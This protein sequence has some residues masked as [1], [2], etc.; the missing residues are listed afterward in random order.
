MMRRKDTPLCWSRKVGTFFLMVLA[1]VVALLGLPKPAAAQQIRNHPFPRTAQLQWGGAPDEWYAKFD[2]LFMRQ[3]NKSYID[4]IRALNPNLIWLVMR[5]FNRADEYLNGFPDSWF[6]RDSRGNKIVLYGGNT[7]WAN[8]SELAPRA[9]GSINGISFSNQ[10]LL[11]FFPEELARLVQRAGSEGIVSDG[12]Y[13]RLHLEWNMFPDVDLDNNGQNDLTE[14]GKGKNWVIERWV[15]GVDKFLNK[16]RSLLGPNK[17][18][19]INTGSQDL[20][21]ASAVNGLYF[22]NT[23][24]LFNWD[25]DKNTMPQLHSRA[26]QPPIFTLNNKTDPSNPTSKGA[27]GSKNDFI[28][29]RFGLARAMLFGQ[30]FDLHTWESGEHY[31]TEYYDEFD[32]DVGYPTGNMYEVKRGIWVRFFDKGAVIANV[33]NTNTTVTDAELRSAPGYAGPYWR[34]QGGQDPVMN[35]GQQFNSLTLNGHSFTGYGNATI[36]VGDGVVLVKTPQT[37]VADMVIDNVRSATTAG[38]PAASFSG[39][40]QQVCEEGGS[41]YYTLRCASW[42]DNSYGMHLTTDRSAVAAFRPKIGVSGPYEVFEWHG[43][44]N[45]G[46]AATSVTY[47]ITHTGGSA[48]KTVNQRNNVGRWNSLGVYLFNAGSNAEVKILSA[49]ASGT[50]VADAIKFVYQNGS[51]PEPDND[52]PAPPQNVRIEN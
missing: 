39:S 11:D 6:L 41:Q 19:V 40:W 27:G 34:F 21:T 32:L 33:N 9:S 24:G 16:L 37:V 7:Y 48:N 45:S 15:A 26:A 23:G 12:L 46:D 50:V 14:P 13:Y 28:Y 52:P 30:Y 47:T 10:T 22:E 20:P 4:R 25:Y 31:W 49:G 18:I 38:S 43:Q 51:G 5:D 1:P 2:L 44:P 35:N 3:D 29:M 42:V 17:L 36:I 8:L